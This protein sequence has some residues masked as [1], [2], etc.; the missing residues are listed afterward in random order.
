MDCAISAVTRVFDALW[1]N[2]SS[3]VDAMGFASLNPS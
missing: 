2:P 1:R 3:I